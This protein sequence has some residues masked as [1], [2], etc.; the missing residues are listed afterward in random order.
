MEPREVLFYTDVFADRYLVHMCTVRFEL[1]EI[2]YVEFYKGWNFLRDVRDIDRLLKE[3][4]NVMIYEINKPRRRARNLEIALKTAYE[5]V[6]A[7]ASAC[8]IGEVIPAIGV[9]YPPVDL[10]RRVFPAPFEFEA[11]PKDLDKYL[12]DLVRNFKQVP[13]EIL[14][15]EYFIF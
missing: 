15:A 12:K 3:A 1:Y 8:S 5:K 13:K 4:K 2:E 7:F 11:F 14:N 6:Y 10:I 9:G